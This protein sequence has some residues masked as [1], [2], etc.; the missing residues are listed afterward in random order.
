MVF[1]QVFFRNSKENN[2]EIK[3]E[4]KEEEEME[5]TRYFIWTPFPPN[6]WR[7]LVPLILVSTLVHT[8]KNVQ[9]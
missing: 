9:N 6:F 4:P 3:E 1:F 5:I 8:I 2:G 7:C